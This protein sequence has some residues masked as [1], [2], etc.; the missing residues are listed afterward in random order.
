ME[1]EVGKENFIKR[2]WESFWYVERVTK[3]FIIFV[4][5]FLL[6]TTTKLKQSFDI[7]QNAQADGIEV[8]V[9]LSSPD[10]ISQLSTGTTHTQNTADSW[11]NTESV[12][13]ARRL[14]S[15]STSFQNQHIM[16][17]GALNPWPDNTASD[18]S[19]WNWESLDGR[20]DLIRKTNGIPVITLCCS[21]DWMKGGVNGQTDWSKLEDPPLPEHEADFAYLAKQVALRYS[22]VKYFQVWN[23]LKGMWDSEKNRW[24]Y[25]RYTRL[26]NLVYDAIKS[27]RPDANIGGPYVVMDTWSSANQ[28][29][30]SK[31][32]GPYGVLDQRPMDVIMYW[33]KNKHGADFITIDG[34]P[35]P[36]DNIWVADEFSAGQYF[37][38]TVSWIRSLDNSSYPGAGTL[39]IFWAEWYAGTPNDGADINHD[40]AVMASDLIY[41]VKSGAFVPLVW[42]PQG[43][44]NGFAFPVGI[45]TDTKPAGGGKATPFYNVQKY[46]K[47]YFPSGTKLYKASVSSNDIGVLASS[48]KTLLV[49]RK[50]VSKTITVNGAVVTLA[51]YEVKVVNTF[52]ATPTL[53][54][55]LTP[56]ITPTNTPLPTLTPMVTPTIIPTR[57]AILTP[58][59]KG[60]LTPFPRDRISPKILITFPV[61]NTTILRNS[62]I[63]LSASAS[64][65]VRVTRVIFTANNGFF[66]TDISAPYSCS[67]LTP[68]QKGYKLIIT[69]RAYDAS[70]N[71]ASSTV[72]VT[73]K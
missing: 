36:K 30:P 4:L 18:S 65:N 8:T 32:S 28:S 66:C 6:I 56:T 5:V 71:M 27:V 37:V 15:D 60:K 57:T 45:W 16:G 1:K 34:G 12:T 51:P 43:D 72:R 2:L 24:D 62:K 11:N 50:P 42:S 63:I 29:H 44:S 47:D 21:P 35:R 48:V 70:G 33:L 25:E 58:V 3:I 59:L 49:N 64:D 67:F 61:N 10:G 55:T 46:F 9:D 22:D 31:I 19:K 53:S 73:T 54:P 39:P 26:Y 38:D 20:I 40:T 41:T 14:L 23:E 7:K 52:E 68:K 17:W 69:A 13:S